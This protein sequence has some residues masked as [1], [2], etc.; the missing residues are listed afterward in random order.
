VTGRC[1]C[2][3]GTLCPSCTQQARTALAAGVRAITLKPRPPAVTPTVAALCERRRDHGITLADMASRILR[4]ESLVSKWERG[5]ISSPFCEAAYR[6]VLD[7]LAT[8]GGEPPLVLQR[9]PDQPWAVRV[10]RC[11]RRRRALNITCRDAAEWLG[12]SQ[13]T[14]YRWEEGRSGPQARYR[15][16]KLR[17]YEQLVDG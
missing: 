9:H 10:A 13:A 6:Q 14:L 16:V 4:S 11:M 5:H 1:G 8:D 15:E 2:H 7:Q 12:V 3:T 17:L